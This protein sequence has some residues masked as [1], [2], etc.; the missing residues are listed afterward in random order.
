MRTI[1]ILAFQLI[2]CYQSWQ[3]GDQI[4][5][6]SLSLWHKL[7]HAL[8]MSSTKKCVFWVYALT[9]SIYTVSLLLGLCVSVNTILSMSILN[10]RTAQW[11]FRSQKP[12]F[13]LEAQESAHITMYNGSTWLSQ[14]LRYTLA[15]FQTII[16]RINTD[17][18]YMRRLLEVNVMYFRNNCRYSKNKT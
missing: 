11:L 5:S 3:R 7:H 8:Q 16:E 13:R 12:D 18:Y 4:N 1:Q 6:L 2:S 17:T 9:F 10:L 14:V 15:P